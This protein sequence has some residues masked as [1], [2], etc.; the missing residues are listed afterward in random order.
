MFSPMDSRVSLWISMACC[1]KWNTLHCIAAQ[2]R[3]HLFESLTVSQARC[4]D[5]CNR[6]A[7][8]W[9]FQMIRV[10]FH[11]FILCYFIEISPISMQAILR[12]SLHWSI[13]EPAMPHNSDDTGPLSQG[14]GGHLS[15]REASL[16]PEQPCLRGAQ[17][18]KGSQWNTNFLR[19]MPTA[20]H[21][22]PLSDAG[23]YLSMIKVPDVSKME[24]LQE[25]QWIFHVSASLVNPARYERC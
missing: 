16:N 21:K 20:K 2:Q 14:F 12:N 1:K 3:R 11:L 13:Q 5:K 8:I 17:C 4:L 10:R 23:I 18:N 15:C 6:C 22:F 24:L 9:E 25:T 19:I 7:R